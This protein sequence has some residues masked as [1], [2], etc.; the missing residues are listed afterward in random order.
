MQ[1]ADTFR[2]MFFYKHSKP[3]TNGS[4]AVVV[5]CKCFSKMAPRVEMYTA[6]TAYFETTEAFDRLLANDDV[7]VKRR[8]LVMEPNTLYSYSLDKKRDVENRSLI[9]S[10]TN[11]FS[12]LNTSFVKC[13]SD[14]AT[15]YI[16]TASRL[17]V[18]DTDEMPYPYPTIVP[19]MMQ[20]NANAKSNVWQKR[21]N[22]YDDIFSMY[23]QLFGGTKLTRYVDLA[24]ETIKAACLAA[25]RFGHIYNG[26]NEDRVVS[27]CPSV[28][29]ANLEFYNDMH[30]R[31]KSVLS[32][33]TS[34]TDSPERDREYVAAYRRR[35]KTLADRGS[36]EIRK[37][38]QSTAA[39]SA[40]D[41]DV[42]SC[43]EW[44]Q[45]ASCNVNGLTPV[46]SCGQMSKDII[47][48]DPFPNSLTKQIKGTSVAAVS[49]LCNSD[50]TVLMT[51][52]KVKTILQKRMN[53]PINTPFFG[54]PVGLGYQF[55]RL[56][57]PHKL[58]QKF[59][60]PSTLT[61]V[62]RHVARP[63]MTTYNAY[64]RSFINNCPRIALNE[65][66][67]PHMPVYALCI[68]VDS[69]ELVGSYYNSDNDD[70]WPVRARV[71]KG[72]EDSME[73]FME[74]L[75][76]DGHLGKDK[77]EFVMYAY[78][79]K[80]ESKN[81]V[82]VG[83]RF[84]YK[85]KYLVF[86]NTE[87][88]H[89]FLVAF[90]F[91]LSKKIP[92]VAY[93]MDLRM[94]KAYAGMLRTVMS[95]KVINHVYCRELMPQFVSA[96]FAFV[97]DQTLFHTK[98]GYLA[99]AGVVVL[100]RIGDITPLI[101]T[102]RTEEFTLQKKVKNARRAMSQS[103][104]VS[105]DDNLTY[106]KSI[107]RSRIMPAIWSSGGGYEDEV[108]VDVKRKPGFDFT[109]FNLHP[110]I[111]WC[112][113]RHHRNPAGNPCRYFIRIDRETGTFSLNMFC[114]GCTVDKDI[115]VDRLPNC[116]LASDVDESK[117]AVEE[118][119]ALFTRDGQSDDTREEEEE[120]EDL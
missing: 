81:I 61:M 68:D 34:V 93:S 85:F 48:G 20:Y 32:L 30:S 105:R 106:F 16:C 92:A 55:C 77:R 74:I 51:G 79:S 24:S 31:F 64:T 13:S 113:V 88:V 69:K 118:D 22:A 90:R 4:A 75:D 29:Y 36:D 44:D 37:Y 99:K 2:L 107:L 115:L 66:I 84:I 41:S 112:T 6:Y 11:I 40:Y 52:E 101:K 56:V 46:R 35:I 111:H 67:N 59:T 78:E 120:E 18:G 98:H 17:V 86:R 60:D 21:R 103:T 23:I 96:N 110:M 49:Y 116:K 14:P 83:L 43:Y 28:T 25:A 119:D 26:Y 82:K 47:K 50:R 10:Q 114:F 8:D 15:W 45:T 38:V 87:V 54:T 70:S 97:L 19:F 80:P 3:L 72:M 76:Q 102:T 108:L 57:D 33:L 1:T 89:N 117:E 58:R 94:F 62:K 42:H 5:K 27:E 109:E 9:T 95:C 65:I 39:F 7:V 104:G 71:I 63:S 12:A 100:D 53:V 73:E 91:F